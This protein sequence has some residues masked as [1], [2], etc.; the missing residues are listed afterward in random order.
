MCAR[1]PAP[2]LARHARARPHS[3]TDTHPRLA[4]STLPPSCCAAREALRAFFTTSEQSRLSGAL[5]LEALD[6]CLALRDALRP[7]LLQAALAL[8]AAGAQG[9]GADDAAPARA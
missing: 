4:R 3:P 5:T 2:A 6:A 8:P 7:T 9:G 1:P